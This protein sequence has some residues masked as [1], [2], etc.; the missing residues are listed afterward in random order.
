M[1]STVQFSI[2][3]PFALL[4]HFSFV[5][6]KKG[7]RELPKLPKS[8]R[9]HTSLDSPND[10]PKKKD[11][12][13]RSRHSRRHNSKDS[14]DSV[15]SNRQHQECESTSENIPNIPKKSR[16]KKSKESNNV[17]SSRSGSRS[18]GPYP[19]PDAESIVP[20]IEQ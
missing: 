2:S 5:D 16:R 15:K 10:S 19:G 14:S 18:K 13:T 12:S 4:K 8:S 17:G 7:S 3:I 1:F 11:G 9:R 6:S 20:R